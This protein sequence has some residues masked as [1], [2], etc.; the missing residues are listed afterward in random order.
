MVSL[1]IRIADL[2]E[3]LPMLKGLNMLIEKFQL[4]V[5]V[6]YLE[7]FH[8]T[9]AGRHKAVPVPSVR[10]VSRRWLVVQSTILEKKHN[11]CLHDDRCPF[12]GCVV[13]ISTAR[14][15]TLCC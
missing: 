4:Y 7:Y 1:M 13:H 11:H 14:G 15:I 8:C 9:G 10:V 2:L 5:G 12:C 6:R 3:Y